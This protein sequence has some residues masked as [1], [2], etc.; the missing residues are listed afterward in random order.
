MKSFCFTVDDNIRFLKELCQRNC[1]SLFDHPYLNMY[2]RLHDAFGL[3]VQLNLFYE[4]GGFDLSQMTDKYKGE[5]EEN[6][7][8]LKLSFHS[9]IENVRPYQA[10][11][12]EEVYGDCHAVQEEILRFAGPATLGKTTTIHYCLT[13]AE[14]LQALK[15]NGVRGLLG[16]YGTDAEPR[17][18]YQNTPEEG[19][20]LRRGET[21]LSNG[22]IY[23]GIDVILN[24]FPMDNMLYRLRG[25]LGREFIKVMIHEQF[26]Y[27]DFYRYQSDFEEKL[28]ATFTCL[29]ENGYESIFFEEKLPRT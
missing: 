2:R 19:A 20:A 29:A 6:A 5:W 23:G 3:K 21:L 7:H 12:Y 13:T 15:D 17:Q 28:T 24:N 1:Q 11:P 8:W 9:K 14:G 25:R 27:E 26:F 18:S 16:L 10:S 4:G 22:V